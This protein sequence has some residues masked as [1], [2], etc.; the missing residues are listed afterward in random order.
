MSIGISHNFKDGYVDRLSGTGSFSYS[1]EN[2]ILKC[3]S[4]TGLDNGAMKDWSFPVYDGDKIEFEI[5][6]RNIQGINRIAIDFL[7]IN[8]KKIYIPYIWKEIK[9]KDFKRYRLETIVP[10][11]QEIKRARIVLGIWNSIEQTSESEFT[12]PILKVDSSINSFQT[13]A[14]GLISMENGSYKINKNFKHFGFESFEYNSDRNEL[15]TTLKYGTD[16]NA[17]P[18]ILATATPDNVFIPLVGK[19]NSNDRTFSLSLTDGTKKI[20]LSTGAYYVY[21][22]VKA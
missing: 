17:R 22:E 8:G 16:V 1:M 12:R 11:G 3:I 5:Y 6:A 4:P 13:I 15:L 10:Y 9:G 14:I 19:W 21:I 20:D 7:D 18:I 2:H